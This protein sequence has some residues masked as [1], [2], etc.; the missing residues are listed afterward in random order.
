MLPADSYIRVSRVGDRAGDSY[1]SPDVQRE[2]N[3]AC[4]ERLGLALRENPPEENESG[5]TMDRPIFNAIMERIRNG[6]SGGIIVYKLDRF[7][8]NLVGGYTALTEIAKSGAV[9]ASASEPQFDFASAN[10]RMMLQVHLMMAEYFRELTKDSWATSVERAVGRGVHPAP[11]GAYGYDRVSGR[12]LPNDEAPYALEAFRLRVEERWSYSA[13]AAWLNEHAP[14]RHYI[15]K[16]NRKRT[17][18]WTGPAVQRMMQRRVYVGEAFYRAHRDGAEPIVN[19]TAHEPIV[20]EPLFMAAQE[21]IHLH[22]KKRNGAVALL[23]GI[24]RC[25]GCRYVMS[26]GTVG[27]KGKTPPLAVYRCRKQYVSGECPAPASISAARLEAYVEALLCAELDAR[28]GHATGSPTTNELADAELE[29]TAVRADLEAMRQDTDARR[30]LGT[31]WLAWIEPYLEREQAA[32]ERL[33]ELQ[34][35]DADTTEGLTTDAYRSLPREERRRVL[36]AF[37]GAVMVRNVPGPRGR[38]TVPLD[39]NRIRILSVRS[40]RAAEFPAKSRDA[41]FIA[42]WPWPEGEA[43]AGMLAG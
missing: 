40:A 4:A 17:P 21:P 27:S 9:F 26:P 43:S 37:I 33:A 16:A 42:P 28:A 13:I 22:S 3:A 18:P 10:G 7:A 38:H 5:G 35:R 11:Y 34:R 20:P 29:L 1:I 30:R 36:A 14:P 24:V 41:G 32:L 15:D 6:E 12:F 19:R 25:A 39:G 8:R 2:A 31:G 23:Q